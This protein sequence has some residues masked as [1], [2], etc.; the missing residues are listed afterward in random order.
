MPVKV[1]RSPGARSKSRLHSKNK[2]KLIARLAADKKA[3]DVI[4]LDIGKVANIC[5]YF[6]ICNGASDRQVRA[7]AEGI[8]VG[9][10]EKKFRIFHREGL[11][12]GVWAL[13]DAG[14]VIAHIFH[15]ESRGFYALEHLWQD[16]KRISWNSKT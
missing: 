9:L 4:V 14:D 2:A 3:E 13:L 11:S 10:K 16:A 6:V 1:A 5:E 8:E 7:I 15:K 12:E